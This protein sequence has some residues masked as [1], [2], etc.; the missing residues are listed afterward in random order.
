MKHS[1]AR[2]PKAALDDSDSQPQLSGQ[3]VAQGACQG[4][5]SFR[6]ISETMKTV[7]VQVEIDY[8]A[9]FNENRHGLG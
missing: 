5:N 2:L 6:N 3:E 8:D 7:T 4:V 1:G 9:R